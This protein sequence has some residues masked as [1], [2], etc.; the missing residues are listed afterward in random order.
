[1]FYSSSVSPISV[2]VMSA[3]QAHEPEMGHSKH[4]HLP[5][6]LIQ[7]ITRSFLFYFLSLSPLHLPFHYST[8]RCPEPLA[9]ATLAALKR[10]FL[11]PLFFCLNSLFIGQP[12]GLHTKCKSDHWTLPLRAFHRL[13]ITLQVKTKQYN[14]T[15]TTRLFLTCPLLWSPASPKTRPL[16]LGTPTL[17]L[18][19]CLARVMVSK[20]TVSSIEKK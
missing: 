14:T 1:M 20:H 9:W 12:R 7:P 4:V 10:S 13:P 19:Y 16:P 2:K 17:V 11:F 5:L 6:T 15:G 8:L 3:F 18:F